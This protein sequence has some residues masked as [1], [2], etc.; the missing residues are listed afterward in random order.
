MHAPA[1]SP[2]PQPGLGFIVLAGSLTAFGAISIDLYLPALP[3]IAAHY[4]ASAAA[5]QFTMSAF[6]AG[7]AIGQL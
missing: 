5:A 3:A 6:L 4:G 1:T 2:R 7:M